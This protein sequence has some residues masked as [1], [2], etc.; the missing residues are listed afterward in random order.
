M[1]LAERNTGDFILKKSAG[2]S[3]MECLLVLL[4]A[5]ILLRM[6]IPDQ[7]DLLTQTRADSNVNTLISALTFA[8]NEAIMRAEKIIVCGSVDK[9]NCDGS[10]SN[11]QIII[12]QNANVI[13]VFELASKLD[14]LIWNSSLN[15]DQSIEWLPSG[16]TSGQRGSFYLCMD[17]AAMKSQKIV[18]LNTGRI[19][20]DNLTREEFNKNCI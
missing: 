9:R 3:L 2:F 13:R 18:L 16:F 5:S 6:V 12:D 11:S 14:R 7:H 20:S 1:F 17:H 15:R 4:L 8:R 19:Y 10:W